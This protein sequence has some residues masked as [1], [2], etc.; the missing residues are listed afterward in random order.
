MKVAKIN[1]KSILGIDEME[2]KPGKITLVEG[3]NGAGK[4]SILEAIKAALNTLTP[5]MRVGRQCQRINPHTKTLRRVYE[6]VQVQSL[7][8]I[9]DRP[10]LGVGLQGS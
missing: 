5:V 2:I 10:S 8:D 4:T 3:R 7:G 1:I 6:R 9:Q